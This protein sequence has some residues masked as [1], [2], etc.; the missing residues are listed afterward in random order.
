MEWG[1]ITQVNV[2]ASGAATTS[3][4]LSNLSVRT[5]AGAGAQTLIVGFAVSDGTKPLLVRGIGPALTSFGVSGALTDPRL[6]LYNG[7]S[8]VAENDNWLAADAVTFSRVGA[9]TLGDGSRDSALV[10]SLAPGSYTAQ[11]SGT[12]GGTGVALVELYDAAGVAS[13]SKLTNV[14]AR[15]EVGAGNETLIAGFNVSGIGPRTLLIRA[16]GPSLAEFGVQGALPDPKLEL[17]GRGEKLQENDNW[18]VATR[19]LFT[20]I[21]AFDLATG[22]RDA[23]LLVTLSP[24]SYTAQVSGVAGSSGVTLVEVYEVP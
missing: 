24:G 7:N 14:S 1:P 4:Y 12:V 21:G 11:V 2:V 16:V 17:F 8:K 22:S 5:S 15:S 20:R 13:G 9:F 19:A 3:S 10:V 6:E 18:D 23:V